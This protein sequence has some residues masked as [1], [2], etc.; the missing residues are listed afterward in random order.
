MKKARVNEQKI[1]SRTVA[2]GVSSERVVVNAVHAITADQDRVLA[3]RRAGFEKLDER[4]EFRVERA[5]LFERFAIS[6]RKP[7]RRRRPSALVPRRERGDEIA[8]ES[9][10]IEEREL[11]GELLR[12]A[13]EDLFSVRL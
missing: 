12:E 4:G 9:H 11:R 10:A 5:Q 13:R 2:S 7:L 3:Q 6:L 1:A 8:L